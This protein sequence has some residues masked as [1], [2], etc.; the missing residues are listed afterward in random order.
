M[1]DRGKLQKK[2]ILVFVLLPSSRVSGAPRVLRAFF[3]LPKNAK[4]TTPVLQ[5]TFCRNTSLSGGLSC[6]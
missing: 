4:K 3:H 2:R 5:A 1:H 6:Y